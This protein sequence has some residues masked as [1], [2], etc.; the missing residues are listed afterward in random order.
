MVLLY[1]LNVFK[2]RTWTPGR[3]LQGAEE[4]EEKGYIQKDLTVLYPERVLKYYGLRTKIVWDEEYKHYRPVDELALKGQF[5]ILYWYNPET[6]L[7][8]FTGGNGAGIRTYDPLGESITATQ[9]HIESKR[10]FNLL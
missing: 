7:H 5:E 9:G 2:N 1:Y 3:I 4:L 6:D 10:I 8:H